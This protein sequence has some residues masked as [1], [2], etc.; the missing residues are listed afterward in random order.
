[1]LRLVRVRMRVRVSRVT[2]SVR[3]T[4]RIRLEQFGLPLVQP[5]MARNDDVYSCRKTT[6]L[7]VRCLHSV[8]LRFRKKLSILPIPQL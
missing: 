6:V 7:H 4:F 5:N 2:V 8:S 1:M 3:V